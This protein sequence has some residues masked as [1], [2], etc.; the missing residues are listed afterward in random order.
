MTDVFNP[1]KWNQD[2]LEEGALTTEVLHVLDER[3]INLGESVIEQNINNLNVQNLRILSSGMLYFA[4]DNSTQTTAF[5]PNFVTNQINQFVSNNNT[6]T[7][8]QKFLNLKIVDASGNET[9]IYQS[10]NNVYLENTENDGNIFFY[11]YNSIVNQAICRIDQFGNFSSPNDLVSNRVK[12]NLVRINNV[13]DIFRDGNSFAFQNNVNNGSYVFRT[14]QTSGIDGWQLAFEPNGK[15]YGMS[16]IITH[17]AE[18]KSYK[19]RDQT[20]FNLTDSQIF[21]S[22]AN[23]LIFDNKV[24]SQNTKMRFLNYQSNGTQSEVVIDQFGNMSGINDLNLKNKLIFAN[25][26]ITHQ[27][28]NSQYI[29]DNKNNGSSIKIRNYDNGAVMRE[30]TID[31]LLNMSGINNFYCNAFYLGGQLKNF[32][33]YDSVVNK[34]SIM[35]YSTFPY[36]QVNFSTSSGQVSIVPYINANQAYNNITKEKDAVLYFN[37]NIASALSIVP[38]TADSTGGIRVTNT[39]AEMYKPKVMDSLTFPDN[40]QQTTAM[41]TSYLTSMIQS[42]VSQMTIGIPSGSIVAYGGIYLDGNL[43]IISPP[44][45]YLWCFGGLVSQTTYLNLFNAIGHL[46]AYGRT[47]PSGQFYLPDM[48][49]ATLKGTQTNPY[50]TTQTQTLNP[51][52]IQQNNVGHHK[53]Q[54]TDR[55]VDERQFSPS[56]TSTGIKPSNSSYYTQ[57]E[58]YDSITNNIL[59]TDTRVNSVAVNYIIKI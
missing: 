56:G 53:H 9:K 39:Q 33:D 13:F 42:V 38:W 26:S 44:V 22:P 11:T 47:I 45:G 49:G 27:Y 29:I 10:G 52:E 3:Y 7:G 54:Y 23:D 30:I 43:D 57:G 48:R 14:K 6:F 25:N 51:G 19:F 15:L 18:S 46:Y 40:T 17:S 59:D 28:S 2:Q 21:L 41:T 32:N 36:Q 8:E 58:T 31:P 20:S 4:H 34:T 24:S 12:T 37:N 50:F 55:G 1:K 5:N 35:S 16:N